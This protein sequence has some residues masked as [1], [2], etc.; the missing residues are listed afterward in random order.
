[1]VP[2][3]TGPSPCTCRDTRGLSLLHDEVDQLRALLEAAW[4]LAVS[5]VKK[6]LSVLRN[7][8]EDAKAV[9]QL[10]VQYTRTAGRCVV[11]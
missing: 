7:L 6:P 1:M 2:L 5:D 10:F 3:N 9:E 8:Q 11:Y 4:I